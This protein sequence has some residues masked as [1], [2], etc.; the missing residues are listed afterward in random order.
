MFFISGV[1]DNVIDIFVLLDSDSHQ[2][3]GHLH[4]CSFLP[5]QNMIKRASFTID[6]L[7]ENNRNIGV[8]GLNYFNKWE[9]SFFYILRVRIG[10]HVEQ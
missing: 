9:Q 7:L 6:G 3:V 10:K 8:C 1:R 5:F 2:T 4:F